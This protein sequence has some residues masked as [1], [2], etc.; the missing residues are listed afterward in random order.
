MKKAEFADCKTSSE[1]SVEMKNEGND[2]P[3]IRTYRCIQ[4]GEK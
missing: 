1:A 2:F 3:S 4:V